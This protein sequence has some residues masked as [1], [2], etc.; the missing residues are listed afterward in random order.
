MVPPSPALALLML[1]AS[2]AP[3]S[4]ASIL[5]ARRP[6]T[7][8]RRMSTIERIPMNANAR[9]ESIS[10][11]S[12][13]RLVSTRSDIWNRYIG[14]VSIS[15]FTTTEN[16]A[17][18]IRFAR[19]T[20]RQAASGLRGPTLSRASPTGAGRSEDWLGSAL[21]RVSTALMLGPAIGWHREVQGDR[22]D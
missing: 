6:S 9:A 15:K 17:T 12:R 22:L 13:L 14:I 11:V 2:T 7:C 21:L 18:A 16:A 3:P 20:E 4:K 10:R 5:V 1:L 19:A 8:R